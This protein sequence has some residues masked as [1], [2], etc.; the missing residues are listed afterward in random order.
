MA[1]SLFGKLRG[2]GIKRLREPQNEPSG[3]SGQ[4]CR[5]DSGPSDDGN[6]RLPRN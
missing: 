2:V 5:D 1:R 4:S 6:N 3:E